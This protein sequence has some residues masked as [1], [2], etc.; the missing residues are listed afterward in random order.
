[1]AYWMHV[2]L[3]KYRKLTLGDIEVIGVAVEDSYRV[4]EG[5]TTRSNA[6]NEAQRSET[7]I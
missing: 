3:T 4:D 6:G 2:R 7:S 1:M 5:R